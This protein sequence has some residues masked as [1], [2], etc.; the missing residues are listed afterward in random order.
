MTRAWAQFFEN[1]GLDGFTDLNHRTTSVQRQIRDNG[2]TYNV[3]ADADGPQRPWSLD[4]FPLILTPAEWVQIE[5]GVLQRM[6]LLNRVLADVYG[7]QD[8]LQ[9]G[10]LPPALVHGHP[11]YLQGM[12]GVLPVGG[13]HL[14]IAAFDLARGPDGQWAVVTQRT[15]AP[16][17]LGYLLENRLTISRQF[18]KAFADLRVQRLAATYRALVDGMKQMCPTAPGEAPRIVLLTPGPHNETYFEH[19][20]LA[21][22]LG[23]TLVE[24]GDLTVRGTHLYLKTL[25][26]LEPVHGLLKRLDD[27]FLD[28]LELRADS[29]LGVPGLLQVVRAGHVLLANAPGSAFLEST[30]L[31]GFLP[32]LSRHLLDQDLRMPSLPTWWC[33]EQAAM[34][35][36]LPRLADSVIKPTWP[37]PI[38]TLGQQLPRRSLD[39]WAGRIARRGDEYTLQAYSPLSQMPTWKVGS[40]GTEQIAMR[41][42]ALRVFALADGPNS[43]RVLPSGLARLAGSELHIASMQ[44]GGSS[45]DVW[46]Q[47]DP[48]AGLQ[49]D[50]TTLLH[51]TQPANPSHQRHSITSRAAENLFWLGRYTERCE[52]TVHLARLTLSSLNGEDQNAVPLLAWLSTLAVRHF[53]VLP[54]VPPATTDSSGSTAQARR[55]FE[56]SLMAAL[57]DPLQASVGADLRALKTVASSV[58]ERLSLEQWKLIVRAEGE[59]FSQCAANQ[60]PEPGQDDRDYSAVEFLRV[61]D[62]VSSHLAAITGAQTDRMT[63]D[64]GWR[65]LSAG[66]LIERLGFLAGALS[67]GFETDAVHD[68]AGFE[69]IVA[70]FDSTITFH[71]HYQQRHDIAALLDLLMLDRDN[72]HS[73]GWVAQTLRGRVAKLAGSAPGDLPPI[74]QVVPDPKLWR[75]EELLGTDSA[76]G[77]TGNMTFAPFAPFKPFGAP[78][79]AP[80]TQPGQIGPD[81]E[82]ET[83]VQSQQSQSADSEQAPAAYAMLLG[84][85]QRCQAAAWQLSDDLSTRYFTHSAD[86]RQSLGA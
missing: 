46:V 86:T 3:Y 1:L 19:A 57:A 81:G 67:C 79:S 61:L 21:R 5:A 68:E 62:T 16:S 59:F 45:A 12:H 29:T 42:V 9:T 66:R 49:V 36:V 47:T 20:Y 10:L 6:Q 56:R 41:S 52:N 32:A 23:L 50:T 83:L 72:P 38:A 35:A 76:Q 84:E 73:L 18:P 44:R 69:A 39:E 78:D 70:L 34:Q 15:Q 74:A 43:W 53:L 31:L 22:Y 82:T 51:H 25:R 4:L 26:G 8:L 14:H 28:P 65:L 54:S 85:L 71:T 24:G 75:L 13:H 60:A 7:P 17:G 27:E 80:S 77:S 48:Q 37:G 55:V 63:R 58:R 64:D 40:D 2:V 33:G 11:G 30:A